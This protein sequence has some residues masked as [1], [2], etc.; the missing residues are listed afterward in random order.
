VFGEG[1][2]HGVNRRREI[3]PPL[4]VGQQIHIPAR[5]V[6]DSVR[7]NRVPASQGEPEGS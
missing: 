1:R 2:D 7:L 4:P 3:R 6:A 5:P